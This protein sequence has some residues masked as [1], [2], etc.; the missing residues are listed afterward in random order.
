[1]PIARRACLLLLSLLPLLASASSEEKAAEDTLGFKY[2][3]M[4]PAFVVNFAT[5]GKLGYLKTDVS[6]RVA[7]ATVPA[8]EHHM[9]ALRHEIIMLLSRQT[10]ETLASVEQRET[11]R[12]E[13][14]AAVRKVL[15]EASGQL[16]APAGA[17]QAGGGKPAEQ[18][19]QD[20]LFT[21]FIVQR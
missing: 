15:A 21:S 9:P 10:P 17:M 4:T 2:I 11:M 13:A 12:L 20:L 7:S 8:V 19:V 1:M 16:P 18:P 3:E 5:S 14:L 6:L